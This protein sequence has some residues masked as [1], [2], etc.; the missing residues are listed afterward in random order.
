MT[1]QEWESLCD[2]CAKCCLHKLVD[3][4]TGEYYYTNVSC[5]LLDTYSCRC[6]SYDNRSKLEP[7]CVLLTPDHVSDLSWLPI[8][9]AYRLVAESKELPYWHHLVSGNPDSV[10]IEGKSIRG[11]VVREQ[12]V[13]MKR[14]EEYIVDWINI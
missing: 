2:G 7:G 9:C 13:D 8:T 4:D 12:D 1:H 5:R 14:L 6:T 3:E 11:K 10:H